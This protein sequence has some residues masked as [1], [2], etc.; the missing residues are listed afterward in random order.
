MQAN[1]LD[2]AK[3]GDPQAIATLMNQALNTQGVTIQATLRKECL[4]ILMESQQKLEPSRIV[5]A[6][7]RAMLDLQSP[8]ITKVRV[9]GHHIESSSVWGQVIHLRETVETLEPRTLRGT[10]LLESLTDD[11]PPTAIRAVL[12]RPTISNDSTEGFSAGTVGASPRSLN[13]DLSPL[14]NS[15]PAFMDP[16]FAFDPIERDDVCVVFQPPISAKSQPTDT[17]E[18]TS[19]TA[20]VVLNKFQKKGRKDQYRLGAIGTLA[21]LI[22]GAGLGYVLLSSV[23]PSLSSR[24][25]P[26]ASPTAS[27][28]QSVQTPSSDPVA[29]PSSQATPTAVATDV[30]APSPT[31]VKSIAPTTLTSS[32]SSEPINL[33]I[34]TTG[35]SWVEVISDGKKQYVG[36]LNAGIQ[37]D[38][39]AK[40]SLILR[41]GSAGYVVTSLNQA[42]A[43]PLGEPGEVL[44]LE[45]TPQ[46]LKSRLSSRN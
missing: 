24:T 18:S 30:S 5:P 40:T 28:V 12:K 2:L 10:A 4:H 9:Y 36:I 46:G 42:E 35:K 33:S 7:R 11:D 20:A 25:R 38:W 34:N 32:S 22:C 8:V 31:P 23:Q 3:Q 45:Y 37:K 26:T 1:L 6:L 41:V 17:I 19:L 21:S 39:T 29:T 43:K 27:V 44:E 15:D 13:V 16:E 14:D